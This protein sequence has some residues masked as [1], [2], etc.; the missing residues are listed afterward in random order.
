MS[1]KEIVITVSEDGHEAEIEGVGFEGSECEEALKPFE[2]AFG[3]D[4]SKA[5][6]KPEYYRTP[7][8]ERERAKR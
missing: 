5:K 6:K 3:A 7:A 8:K 2:E 1:E 4:R